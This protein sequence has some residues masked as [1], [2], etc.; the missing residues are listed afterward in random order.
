MNL[1]PELY[2]LQNEDDHDQ[3]KVLLTAIILTFLLLI[4][5]FIL[6]KLLIID[7]I[8]LLI[9]RIITYILKI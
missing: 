5:D 1:P 9:K 6:L 8:C 2:F 3:L 7:I 4:F